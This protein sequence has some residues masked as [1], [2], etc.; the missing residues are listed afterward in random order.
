M[1]PF[2]GVGEC[3]GIAM[4]RHQRRM[5]LAA[6]AMS[7]GVGAAVTGGA[8]LAHADTTE[9]ASAAGP[10]KPH[11]TAGTPH[12]R[13]AHPRVP[14]AGAARNAVLA[15]TPK[16]DAAIPVA[17]V[18]HSPRVHAAAASRPSAAAQTSASAV[19]APPP[20]P[21]VIPR[22]FNALVPLINNTPIRDLLNL[23][24][25]P[26]TSGATVIRL[27]GV[28]SSAV[29]SPSGDRLFELTVPPNPLGPAFYVPPAYSTL[30]EINTATNTVVGVPINIRGV[31]IG[32]PVISADGTRAYQS[33][34]V[35]NGAAN[36]TWVT[37][38]DTANDTVVGKPVRL[39]GWAGGPV[40]LSPDG[41]YAY[42]ATNTSVGGV[43]TTTVTAIDTTKVARV[44]TPLTLQGFMVGPM[45]S[46]LDGSRL[47]VIVERPS[48][49]TSTVDLAVINTADMS[50]VSPTIAMDGSA[51]GSVAVSA[52]GTRAAVTTIA[53]DASS[54]SV[55]V[56][57]VDLADGSVIDTPT[58]YQGIAYTAE[59]AP[60]IFS[61]GGARLNQVT[62]VYDPSSKTTSTVLT[63]IDS[64]TGEVVGAPITI[65]AKNT[66]LGTVL[67]PDPM[68][69]RLFIASP[70]ENQTTST[71]DSTVTTVVDTSD[72][73]VVGTPVVTSYGGTLVAGPD[74]KSVYLSAAF[75]SPPSATQVTV[76]NSDSVKTGT[77]AMLIGPPVAL[78]VNQGGARL[79]QLTDRGSYNEITAID[80]GTAGGPVSPVRVPG[81][82]F[83]ALIAPDGRKIYA[84]TNG[85]SP[86]LSFSFPYRVTVVKTSAIN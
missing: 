37:V 76:V 5:W 58:V 36:S 34:S 21:A 6:G 20:L 45:V 69:N 15:R 26:G 32:D 47:C 60:V 2:G 50:L 86:L 67:V 56:T 72:G 14:S 82:L 61:D 65:P 13:A 83:S 53:G 40:V 18:G 12:Q 25:P 54:T 27:A 51:K 22:L 44:G 4:N 28:P 62:L 3:W 16:A 39:D 55:A 19:P 30:T 43:S 80:A 75:N 1:P 35:T 10:A 68:G 7:V 52:D 8:A 73:T 78:L 46:D 38:I 77:S 57:L 66:R 11:A 59:A 84:T 49:S 85:S 42:Q 81:I 63:V 23:V 64:S 48:D 33:S 70:I 79:Y 31:P 41:R 71:Y 9:S 17:A 24:D 74:G 29:L